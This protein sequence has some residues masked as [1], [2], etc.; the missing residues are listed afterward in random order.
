MILGI[1]HIV[2]A[3][4]PR[5]GKARMR[6]MRKSQQNTQNVATKNEKLIGEAEVSEWIDRRGKKS[7]KLLAASEMK[8]VVKND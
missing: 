8:N 5:G 4:Q 6:K 3:L 2:S 7:G 1:P